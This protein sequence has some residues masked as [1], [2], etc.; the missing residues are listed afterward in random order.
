MLWSDAIRV[1]DEALRECG[2]PLLAVNARLSVEA[3]YRLGIVVPVSALLELE[4][5]IKSLPTMYDTG[6]KT[7]LY[8]KWDV[9]RCIDDLHRLIETHE[10][11]NDA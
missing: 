1:R 4:Q 10:G 5:N 7:G 9:D 8:R 6:A 11:G 3:A 2:G